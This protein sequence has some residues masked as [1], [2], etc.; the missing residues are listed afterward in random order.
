MLVLGIETSCDETGIGLV[1]S[2]RGI[3]GEAVFSQVEIHR[4]HGGVVPELASRDHLRK[5]LPLIEKALG[6]HRLEAVDAVAYT[7]GPGLI[8]ALLTGAVFAHGLAW[9]LARP[10][11]GI[12]HMEAHLLVCGMDENAPAPPYLALLVSG[13]HTQL[14]EVRG[15][16]D[17][18]LLG[19]TLD[20]AV[21]EAF[22][23]VARML[24]LDYP[25]GPAIENLARSGRRGRFHFSRPMSDRPELDFS[26]SGLKT[27]VLRTVQ[28][29]GG[30]GQTAADIALAFEN[31]AVDA[32]MI[33]CRQAIE[34][35]GLAKLVIAGGVAANRSLRARIE[36][37]R[38]DGVQ[39]FCP[40]RELCTD[41]G[42]M[43]AH[44]GLLRL[45]AGQA[46]DPAPQVRARWPI[47]ELRAAGV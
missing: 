4:P 22:D 25:G 8:G 7:A 46:P 47:D 12:H 19:E 9:A 38:A 33:K 13:G 21:G 45:E 29:H 40:A 37:L 28:Q 23:K 34:R 3:V 36:A 16:G 5:I 30:N 35:S 26:F 31:A 32:L 18:R 42:V 39:V 10:A 27:Q 43:I 11:I 24:G 2:Q 17:Y 44:A 6:A 14:I 1:D 41:N 15:L 20:D